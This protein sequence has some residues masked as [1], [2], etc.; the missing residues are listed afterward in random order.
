VLL[1]GDAGHKNFWLVD[2]HTAAERQI[3]ELGPDIIIN[4]FDL[5]RDSNAVL[6]DRTQESSRIARSNSAANVNGSNTRTRYQFLAT[7]DVGIWIRS[8]ALARVL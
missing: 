5:S 1:R 2:L 7:L 3:T 6:F 8:S 4:D